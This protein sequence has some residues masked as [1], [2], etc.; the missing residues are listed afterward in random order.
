LKTFSTPD[1]DVVGI[2]ISSLFGTPIAV[3]ERGYLSSSRRL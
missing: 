3:F 2:F 1:S